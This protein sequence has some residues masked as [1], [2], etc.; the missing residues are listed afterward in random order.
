MP[1]ADR[2]PPARRLADAARALS[3]AVVSTEA[4]AELLAEVADALEAL[5][6]GLTA[7][8]RPAGSPA[9]L[10]GATLSAGDR[11]HDPVTGWANP[12]AAPLTIT[13]FAGRATGSVRLGPVHQG[14]PGAAH[15][16]VLAGLLETMTGHAAGLGDRV[17]LVSRVAVRFRGPVPLGEDLQL[18]SEAT[19]VSP[20][21]WDVEAVLVRAVDPDTVL[22]ESTGTVLELRPDQL[23]QHR[24]LLAGPGDTVRR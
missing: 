9:S 10:D 8:A 18:R 14:A 5:A 6:A 2:P 21:R 13:R 15:G 23:E 3:V 12:V 1:P 19:A 24:V 17:R 16:G 20:T 22:A 7:H 4:P 11:V